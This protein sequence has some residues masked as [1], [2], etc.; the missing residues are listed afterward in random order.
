V[1]VYTPI[2]HPRLDYTLRWIFSFAGEELR[3]TSD[4]SLFVAA[5]GN[6]IWYSNEPCP[7]AETPIFPQVDVLWNHALKPVQPE[8]CYRNTM[9]YPDFDG[10][11]RFDPFAACF[12]LLARYEEYTA[13]SFDEHGRFSGH[14]AW[15][16]AALVRRPWADIWRNEVYEEIRRFYP[17]FHSVV[18]SF[19]TV[20]T[21]DVDSAF[22]FRYKGVRRTLGGFLLD[23]LRLKPARAVRRLKCV[24]ADEQDPFDTYEYILDTCLSQHVEMRCF[25]LLADRSTY[26][27]NVDYRNA[28]LHDRIQD[29]HDGGAQV[30]I[31]PGYESHGDVRIL[32]KEIARLESIM[33]EKVIHSRQHFLKFKLPISFRRLIE[34]GV[35]HDHSMGYADVPGFRS[36]TAHPYKWFDVE[37]NETTS[38]IVHP[39]VVMDSTLRQYL[40]LDALEATQVIAQ[41][42]AEVRATGGDFVSLWHNETVAEQD[43]W[44]GWSAVWEEAIKP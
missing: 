37:K 13:T 12:F 22:A 41:L 23:L 31:H 9:A 15:G 36:G 10:T 11:G 14:G 2:L 42:K 33:G 16:G 24:L 34:C 32:M 21:I 26:D 18:P 28:Q 19:R 17:G 29:M 3:V 5:T 27:I 1:L 44:V 30:G 35:T 38:L 43:E 7:V 40:K 6:R 4:A 39:V 20:A 25:F 8:V